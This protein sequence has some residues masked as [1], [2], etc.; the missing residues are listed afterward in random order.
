MSR[1]DELIQEYC[2]NGVEFLEIKKCIKPVKNI[3]WKEHPNEEHQY[4]DLTSVDR[5]THSI[6]ETQTINASNAPSRA[7][8]IVQVNDIL[9]G[10]TRPSMTAMF[11][12][13]AS[14]M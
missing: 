1:L 3:K 11:F 4:I 6:V 2:P 13:S 14:T 5:N 7:Q 10:A 8:Q 12:R 9:L